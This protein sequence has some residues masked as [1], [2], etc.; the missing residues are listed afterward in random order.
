MSP[1]ARSSATACGVPGLRR[2]LDVVGENRRRRAAARERPRHPGVGAEPPA[3]GRALVDR[4]AHERVAE[5]ELA[6]H[7]G[8]ADEARR[9]QTVERLERVVDLARPPPPAPARTGRPPPPRPPAAAAAGRRA[10]AAHPRS[11]PP[12]R[13]A[14]PRRRARA[15]R[16][17]TGSR[18]SRAARPRAA[19]RGSSRPI[20]CSASSGSSGPRSIRISVPVRGARP[21]LGQ[22]GDR[23]GASRRTRAGGRAPDE[24]EQQLDRRRVRVV[25]VV[26]REHER[27]RRREPPEQLDHRPVRPEALHGERGRRGGMVGERGEDPAELRPCR[28]PGA[29]CPTSV[30]RCTSSASTNGP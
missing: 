26:E 9:E 12:H 4:A 28:A 17:R 6:R 8:R 3:A 22:V 1:A 5:R 14:A 25:H 16:C 15:A 13:P 2:E 10:P 19:R 23:R 7:V 30:P 18:R 21:A 24:R 20:S 11:P 29:A 27:P